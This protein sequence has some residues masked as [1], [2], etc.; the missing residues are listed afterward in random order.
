MTEEENKWDS[1]GCYLEKEETIIPE[2]E[3]E[4]DFNKPERPFS[5]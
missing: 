3:E 2:S 1:E 5:D 4:D